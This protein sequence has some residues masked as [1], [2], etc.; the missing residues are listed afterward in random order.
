VRL[1][2]LRTRSFVAGLVAWSALATAP[3]AALGPPLATALL[4]VAFAL[5]ACGPLLFSLRVGA[6]AAAACAV[7]FWVALAVLA[8]PVDAPAGSGSLLGSLVAVRVALPALLAAV[9][10]A[11]SVAFAELVSMG[12]EW[13]LLPRAGG[14]N[15][16]GGRREGRPQQRV[17][18]RRERGGDA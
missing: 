14:G 13:D 16:P 9:G 8:L 7:L 5:A 11:G 18:V 15:G 2:R 17:R 3:V 10:L 4:L 1:G 12:L 6:A